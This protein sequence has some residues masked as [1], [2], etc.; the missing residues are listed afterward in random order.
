MAVTASERRIDLI[1]GDAYFEVAKDPMRPFVVSVDRARVVAAG[2][3][4]YVERDHDGLIVLVTEGKIR[5][6]GLPSR[7][8]RWQLDLRR[9]SMRPSFDSV[10]QQTWK[11]KKC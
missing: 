5:L 8:K 6:S 9:E 3:Q 4:F 2:T 11:L 7:R 1:H 10:I